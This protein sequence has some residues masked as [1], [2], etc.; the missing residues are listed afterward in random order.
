MI[1]PIDYK[2]YLNMDIKQLVNSLEKE[3]RNEDKIYQRLFQSQELIEFLK[4]RIK[5][6]LDNQEYLNTFLNTPKLNTKKQC[7]VKNIKET[8]QSNTSNKKNKKTRTN[9]NQITPKNN[10]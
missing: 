5:E 4:T 1:K 3:E 8:K 10:Q 7:E 2:E 6:K 9:K